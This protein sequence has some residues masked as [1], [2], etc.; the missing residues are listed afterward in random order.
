[1]LDSKTFNDGLTDAMR[2]QLN[3]TLGRAVEFDQI[4]RTPAWKRIESYYSNLVQQFTSEIITSSTPLVE[5][6]G[7]RSEIQ[8]IRKL[9]NSINNDLKELEN[10]RKAPRLTTE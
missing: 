7:K 4:V 2:E 5:F 8:G 6:E 3:E 9:L 1:M 10:E